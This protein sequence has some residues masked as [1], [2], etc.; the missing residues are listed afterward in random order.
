MG[1]ATPGA[2]PSLA[3]QRTFIYVHRPA[4]RVENFPSFNGAAFVNNR[5]WKMT[6]SP[7]RLG[8]AAGTYCFKETLNL[9][10][11][12]RRGAGAA[13]LELIPHS[14][15]R[16]QSVRRARPSSKGK[17]GEAASQG[18]YKSNLHVKPSKGGGGGWRDGAAAIQPLSHD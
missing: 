18:E 13:A 7:Y 3:T 8:T 12:S 5:L 14:S 9:S 16:M 1:L 4:L 6:V 11:S 10:Q 17:S 2:R 15:S